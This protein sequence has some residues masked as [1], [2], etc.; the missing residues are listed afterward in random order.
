MVIKVVMWLGYEVVD[1][2]GMIVFRYKD[3]FLGNCGCYFYKV[4]LIFK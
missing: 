2:F 1:I 4:M 3:F